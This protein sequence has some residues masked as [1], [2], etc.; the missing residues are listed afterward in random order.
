MKNNILKTLSKNLGFKIL[1]LVFAFALWITVYNLEDP[2]KTKTLTINVTVT[3]KEYLEELG[4]YY[5]IQGGTNKV[6][7]TVTAVRSILDKLDESDFTATANMELLTINETGDG[8]TV[9][10]DIVCTGNVNQ[11]AIKLSSA[12]KTLTVSL[13]ELMTKQFVVKANAVGTVA[14]GYAL[15]GIEVTAPN[16]LKV[17]GP[18]SIVQQIAS[19]VATIDVTD[20]SDSWTTYRATPTLFDAKGN[21]IDTTRLTL[22][23]TTVNVEAEILNTKDVSISVSPVGKVQDGYIVTAIS[24]NP[25]IISLKGNKALLNSF[26]AIE[27]PG[28]LISINGADKNVSTTIDISEYIPAGTEL[29][30]P[31]NA[32]VTITVSVAKIKEKT[33]SVNTENIQVTGLPTNTTMEYALSSVAVN[34]SG[35]ESDINALTNEMI[36]G[37]IDLTNY[38]VGTHEVYLLLDLDETRYAYTPIK[39]TVIIKQMDVPV[40]AEPPVDETVTEEVESTEEPGSGSETVEGTVQN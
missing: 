29:V 4:K 16:V 35:I 26:S 22:S 23:N 10:V 8:G 40:D 38:G 34:L 6:S 32:T 27:I 12:T 13:E 7:F 2:T 1:A 28:E 31:E 21:E 24:S 30:N 36:V 20:M 9:P 33:F 15:G 5:E 19:V 3:N 11:N 14:T 17:S 37:S 25:S 39:V 18:K